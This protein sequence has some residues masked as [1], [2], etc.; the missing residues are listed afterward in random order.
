MP[1]GVII[2]GWSYVVAAYSVTA[3]GLLFYAWTLKRRL[4]DAEAQIE[5]GT[6]E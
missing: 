4:S 5:D 2:G 6:D 3:L 1:E